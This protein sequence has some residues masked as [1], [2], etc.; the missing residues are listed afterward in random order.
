MTLPR[1][2]PTWRS[3]WL[4]VFFAVYWSRIV[5]HGVWFFIRDLFTLIVCFCVFQGPFRHSIARCMTSFVQIKNKSTET[6][7]FN[8]LFAPVC[9]SRLLC[10]QVVFYL[11]YVKI[12]HDI[13]KVSMCCVQC[14]FSRVSDGEHCETFRVCVLQVGVSVNFE[15]L[16][17]R[18]L[19]PLSLPAWCLP[20]I[21]LRHIS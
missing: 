6:S 9:P 5:C 19:R 4:E 7:S 11:K 8:C 17:K 18:K 15:G 21:C 14:I 16:E 20:E 12:K 13:G 10:R 2:Q 3:V 1:C